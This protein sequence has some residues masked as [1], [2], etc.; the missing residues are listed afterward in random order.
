MKKYLIHTSTFWDKPNSIYRLEV[1][2]DITPFEV[3]QLAYDKAYNN[4]FEYC[5]IED[6]VEEEGVD[7][8]DYEAYVECE[9]KV[10]EYIEYSAIEFTGTEEEWDSYAEY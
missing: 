1:K 9:K 3:D 5:S 2:D 6:I 7:P 4:F 10:D 8:R